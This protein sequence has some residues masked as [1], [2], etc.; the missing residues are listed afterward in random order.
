MA[1]SIRQQPIF[2]V[3]ISDVPCHSTFNFDNICSKAQDF[4]KSFLPKRSYQALRDDSPKL[5][6]T[7]AI[8]S[9][10]S[11]NDALKCAQWLLHGPITFPGAPPSFTGIRVMQRVQAST[12]ALEQAAH[13][14]KEYEKN[15]AQW[16]ASADSPALDSLSRPSLTLRAPPT[17]IDRDRGRD[18]G[19]ERS[20]R[21]SDSDSPRDHSRSPPP[22]RRSKPKTGPSEPRPGTASAS[23]AA[24]PAAQRP[25]PTVSLFPSKKLAEK[26][27][28]PKR[29]V[30]AKPVEPPKPEVP[31]AKKIETAKK[32][33]REALSHGMT[34]ETAHASSVMCSELSHAI[35]EALLALGLE[36][37]KFTDKV[38]LLSFNLRKNGDLQAAVLD[39]TTPPEVLVKMTSEDMMTKEQAETKRRIEQ[40]MMDEV[41]VDPTAISSWHNTAAALEMKRSVMGNYVS[42]S[43]DKEFLMSPNKPSAVQPLPTTVTTAAAERPLSADQPLPVIDSAVT[44]NLVDISLPLSPRAAVT[45]ERLN[46]GAGGGG[47]GE[48]A[49]LPHEQP[50]Q[51]LPGAGPAMGPASIYK[52]PGMDIP[53]AV[54]RAHKSV[55]FDSSVKNDN[56]SV[57]GE[58]SR[59]AGGA[60]PSA[61]PLSHTTSSSLSLYVPPAATIPQQQRHA[62]PA[63]LPHDAPLAWG[64]PLM[65]TSEGPWHPPIALYKNKILNGKLAWNGYEIEVQGVDF[66]PMAFIRLPPTLQIKDTTSIAAMTQAIRDTGA[67]PWHMHRFWLVGPSM[68]DVD[69]RSEPGPD[70]QTVGRI[71]V[72]VRGDVLEEYEDGWKR[73]VPHGWEIFI[74]VSCII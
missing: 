72:T 36:S 28:H 46:E 24:A 17:D 30:E 29:I 48:K 43:P 74:M 8:L 61:V 70:E 64:P 42:P 14:S 55:R 34:E 13:Q 40:Q 51:P 2:S 15:L 37:N 25:K 1:S 12:A 4:Y 7:W 65:D 21:S 67:Q 52:R 44:N 23:A 33:I 63:M 68:P 26:T 10:T 19:R 32:V 3:H 54:T 20:R 31:D 35:I 45:A 5:D 73:D 66:S 56:R 71:L 62:T 38:R 69:W 60:V 16:Q 58:S 47:G 6:R 39:G 9:F 22:R 27:A 57:L 41:T 59:Q 50:Q 53:E 18:R 49:V 11:Q